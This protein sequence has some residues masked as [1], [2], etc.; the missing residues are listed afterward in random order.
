MIS[1][2]LNRQKA[3]ALFNE[4]WQNGDTCRRLVTAHV[5][6]PPR[7]AGGEAVLLLSLGTDAFLQVLVLSP[8]SGL[9]VSLRSVMHRSQ[10]RGR[11][12]LVSELEGASG[13]GKGGKKLSW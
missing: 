9:W 8:L 1:G 4:I 12:G 11:Q 13:K 7:E 6:G 2:Q 10:S 5:A 3:G